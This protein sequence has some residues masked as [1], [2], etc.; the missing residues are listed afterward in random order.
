[1]DLSFSSMDDAGMWTWAA[2]VTVVGLVASFGIAV[3][4]Q[5]WRDK[6][7]QDA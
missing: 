7:K 1:M 2:I 3:L 6:K 4:W 5:R